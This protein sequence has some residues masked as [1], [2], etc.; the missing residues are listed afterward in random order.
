MKLTVVYIQDK[1]GKITGSF[2]EKGAL[3]AQGDSIKEVEGK[4]FNLLRS[5]SKKNSDVE[6]I[7]D[8][9]TTTISY[10]LLNID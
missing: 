3:V 9:K 6:Q 1:E 10:N 2:V 7:G 5:F 4:L 8:Y